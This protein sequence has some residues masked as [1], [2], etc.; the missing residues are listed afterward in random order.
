MRRSAWI[1]T[2]LLLVAASAPVRGHHAVQAQFDQDQLATLTG[3]MTRVM[4]IN[5][6]VRWFLDVTDDSGQV[7]SWNISGAAPG[8]F[9]RIGISGREVF[10]TG[11][12]YT[13]TVALARDGSSFGYVVNFVL[14]D[15]R[16]LD[17][18][19]QYRSEGSQ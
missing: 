12:T 14:P 2:L 10:K 5:P 16:Q 6:H 1:S 4:W 15:G 11:E 3:V 9:R 18:W 13:A 8:A 7:T 19:H 17:L